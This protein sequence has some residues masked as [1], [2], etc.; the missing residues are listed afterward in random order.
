M[1]TPDPLPRNEPYV[2]KK[3]EGVTDVWF[4]VTGGRWTIKASADQSE[5]RL[6]FLLGR[7]VRGATPMHVHHTE[8]E[9]V[10][11]IKGDFTL[12]LQDNTRID[13]GPGDFVFAPKGVPHAFMVRSEEAE[14]VVALSPGGV[15]GPAG[16][17]L[18]GMFRQ[19]G[20]PVVEGEGPAEKVDPD[21]KV[22]SEQTAAY[23]FEVVGPP[24]A[25]ED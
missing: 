21:P 3:D 17:G 24:P 7:E 6:Q 25:F 23:Q 15:E 18:N 11:I 8:D 12:V 16:F 20:V 5:G 1:P 10:F 2:L 4:P 19:L 13:A 22:F 14:F 9:C